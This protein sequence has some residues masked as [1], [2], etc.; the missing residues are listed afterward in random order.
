MLYTVR[1]GIV[2]CILSS[3]K[4]DH[5]AV[6]LEQGDDEALCSDPNEGEAGERKKKKE[7]EGEG[8]VGAGV[9]AVWGRGHGV[10][11]RGVVEHEQRPK[12]EVTAHN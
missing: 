3:T 5:G 7:T 11:R 2:L 9:G 1:R 10:G 6:V 4:I 8:G 12:T